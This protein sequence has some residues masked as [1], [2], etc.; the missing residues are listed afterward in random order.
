M[1]RLLQFVPPEAVYRRV[2]L[3]EHCNALGLWRRAAELFVKPDDEGDLWGE[4]I[5]GTSPEDED[6]ALRSAR[7][8]AARQLLGRNAEAL[9]C[10]EEGLDRG[11]FQ[12]A[13]F[14]GLEQV[15]ADS[16]FA[17]KL[18][19]LARL[20]YIR[21]KILAA[22]G[23]LVAAAEEILRLLR[24]G[25]MICGGDGQMLHYLIGLW[26]RSAALRGMARLAARD[27]IPRPLLDD[28][29]GAVRRSLRA[30]DGLAQSLRVDFCTISLPRIAAT[31]D[32]QPLGAVVDRVLA[33]YYAP[34]RPAAAPAESAG[35][36][37][38][39]EWLL[40]RRQQILSMLQGHPRPLDKAATARLMGGMIARTI[41]QIRRAEHWGVFGL[42]GR[43]HH[44]RRRFQRRWLHR[45]TRFWP[46][47][48]TPGFPYESA[49]RGSLEPGADDLAASIST[50]R[51]LVTEATL[52]VARRKLRRIANPIGLVLA[53]HLMAFDYSPFMFQHRTM[54]RQTQRL[55]RKRIEQFDHEPKPKTQDLRPKT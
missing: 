15:A 26:I 16:D 41:R 52:A 18:G 14:R 38:P 54:V 7:G 43:L 28:L 34:R 8:T 55:L 11:H 17:C 4:L 53:E 51:Q 39:G 44:L 24:I 31:V 30:S 36:A 48:L 2:P 1:E 45:R 19:E 32:D 23:H 40:W 6:A 37:R 33:V 3:D 21:A 10:L 46:A 35:E 12:F 22:E 47:A 9:A 25:E 29:L 5:H 20:P 27:D 42:V 49:G 50:A 13:E